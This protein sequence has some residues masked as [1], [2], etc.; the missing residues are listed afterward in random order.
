MEPAAAVVDSAAVA[1]HV[2]GI[3]GPAVRAWL[4]S[5]LPGVRPE[6]VALAAQAASSAA[7]ISALALLRWTVIGF[8]KGSRVGASLVA[9]LWDKHKGWLN[10][11]L[12]LV[13]GHL[14]GS[15][16]AGALAVALHAGWRGTAKAVGKATPQEVARAAR[17]GVVVLLMS[18][19][20]L[21]AADAS[22]GVAGLLRPVTRQDAPMPAF[23]KERF[24]L[25]LG[26]GAQAGGWV[27]SR[28]TQGFAEVQA[29][30]QWT[31]ALGLRVGARRVAVARAP[32]QPEAR[33]VLTFAP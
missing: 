21:W 14:D 29:S 22:A 24:A 8:A 20:A 32:V 15:A 18:G 27:Y 26:V 5:S 31:N 25:S 17:A 19:G 23:A 13:L 7:V 3:V 33:L 10:P 4:E 2:A 9:P 11:L 30:Y 1:T 28:G 16:L 6:V 12:A